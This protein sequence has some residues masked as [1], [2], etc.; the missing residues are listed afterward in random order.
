[1]TNDSATAGPAVAVGGHSGQHE[2][3]G[4]DDDADAEHGEVERRQ[5][6]P[7][8]VLGFVGVPDRLL[9][10]LRPKDAHDA[11]PTLGAANIGGSASGPGLVHRY[12][13]V[14]PEPVTILH[15]TPRHVA[16]PCTP[17]SSIWCGHA[18]KLHRG[19]STP[20]GLTSRSTGRLRAAARCG[21]GGA[22]VFRCNG[23]RQDQRTR[24]APLE[25]NMAVCR[26]V[27]WSGREGRGSGKS[28]ELVPG[29]ADVRVL[30]A[31]HR[32]A[33]TSCGPTPPPA[34]LTGS[35]RGEGSCRSARWTGDDQ[36]DAR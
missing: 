4:A 11:P 5:L 14:N 32:T 19:L 15:A 13:P 30:P 12:S 1:M 33:S 35:S 29:S 9:D 3:A 17:R 22:L 36:P 10:R 26:V 25:S 7:E 18:A 27:G 16:A 2:D 31:N 20:A 6:L 28:H 21:D 34:I 24:G 8:P 23:R